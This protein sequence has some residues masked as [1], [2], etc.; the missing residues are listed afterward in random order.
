MSVILSLE[1]LVLGYGQMPMVCIPDL[2]I[3]VGDFVC[4]VGRSGIGKSTLFKAITGQL[5]PQAGLV[6]Y[7]GRPD[8][9]IMLGQDSKLY[10]WLNVEEN[11]SLVPRLKK[12]P[13]AEIARLVDHLLNATGLQAARA[14][15]P[16]DLSGGMY[17]RVC[18]ARALAAQPELLLLD[19]PFTAQ[20]FVTRQALQELLHQVW[21]ASPISMMMITHDTA[22]A[23]HL[24]QK[25]Y[26]LAGR[27]AQ[28]VGRFDTSDKSSKLQGLIE[29]LLKV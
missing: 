7:R 1:N 21:Q 23:V 8:G 22:E 29:N 15:Y 20:D 18:L 3:E 24:A 6:D 4:V 12:M 17:K 19:E 9:I 14:Q 11:I 27:P 10:P 26:V 16:S 5:K 25:T 28:I 13:P 2:S